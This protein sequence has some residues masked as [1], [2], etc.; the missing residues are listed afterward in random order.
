MRKTEI[1]RKTKETDITLTIDLDGSGKSSIDTGIAFFDHMLS[2]F[3]KHSGIDLTLEA[4]GDIHIDYHHT[5]EDTGIVL[6]QAVKKALG[7]KKGI[8]RF[9]DAT[10]P[11]DEALS[12]VVIDISGRAFLS[13]NV[14][15]PRSDDGSKVNPYLFEEFSEDW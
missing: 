10:I 14:D 11:L 3:V 1:K 8:T 2:S 13:Y 9:A 7:D 4:A 12:R 5:I 6:G 15:F